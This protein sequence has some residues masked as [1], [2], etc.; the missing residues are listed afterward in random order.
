MTDLILSRAACGCKRH[1]GHARRHGCP[2]AEAMRAG[3]YSAVMGVAGESVVARA[4]VG[5]SGLEGMTL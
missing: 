2:T 1:Q 4:Q 3:A 5:L